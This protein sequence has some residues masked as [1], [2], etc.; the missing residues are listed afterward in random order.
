MLSAPAESD[1]LNATN[2]TATNFLPGKTNWLSGTF[3]GW[4]EGNAVVTGDGELLDILRVD[5]SG[6]PEKAALV[7]VTANVGVFSFDP[8]T[9]FIDFPGGAKK[10][11]IRYDSVSQR[12]WS[13]ASIVA[14]PS[15][16]SKP[17]SSI[18]NTLALTC[19]SDLTKW[20]VC[21]VL[22]GHPDADKHGFQ[23]VD[24][25]FQGED[26]I[27]VCRTAYDDEGSGAHSYH[28]ANFLTFHRWRN[29]RKLTSNRTGGI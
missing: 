12:F 16:A 11:T 19:S 24:W 23:Y 6:L 17:P 22:L 15:Q 2:W 25:L 10:F 21:C 9:G 4:L 20:A 8:S 27:A 5:T 28:D 29:F 1:L 7:H 14:E 3:G 26:I 13:V 18:R